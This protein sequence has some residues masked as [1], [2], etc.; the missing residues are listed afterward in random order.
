MH[1]WKILF[2]FGLSSICQA[3]APPHFEISKVG[4]PT[5]ALDIKQ[6]AR[7]SWQKKDDT[8]GLL[9]VQ[10]AL[11]SP[12]FAA[13]TSVRA[14]HRTT[15]TIL[16]GTK[17]VVQM[18]SLLETL[19]LVGPSKTLQLKL[20]V[21]FEES[22]PVI[23]TGC[24]TAKIR[25]ESDTGSV[26]FFVGISC[27]SG[28]SHSITL[29]APQ[30]VNISSSTLFESRGKGEAWRLY[31]LSN[32]RVL[33]DT[34]GKFTFDYRGKSFDFTLYSDKG[35]E[36]DSTPIAL[37]AGLGLGILSIQGADLTASSAKPTLVLRAPHYPV[38]GDFGIGANIDLAF[39]SGGSDAIDYTLFDVFAS[40]ELRLFSAV[41]FRP[42]VG[43]V[44]FATAHQVTQI[45]LAANQ[46]GLGAVFDIRLGTNSSLLVEGMTCMLGS[47]VINSQFTVS[48]SYLHKA[49]GV[50]GWGGG[51]R[52]QKFNADSLLGVNRQF[53]QTVFY[54][55]VTF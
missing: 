2:L 45:G 38:L 39:L 3:A 36:T 53:D 7:W 9:A 21:V 49:K 17:L 12:D 15:R 19:T 25:L 30:E 23:D 50:I 37:L 43:Y 40:Y 48:A 35:K 31:D 32:V 11:V 47:A 6:A 54:A 51:I 33:T 5:F 22:A 27:M 41:R 42:R 1:R 4:D 44:I 20:K 26:P 14:S 16:K 13:Y 10:G 29:T 55:N 24:A 8:E 28:N 18:D 46:I 34:I 52:L